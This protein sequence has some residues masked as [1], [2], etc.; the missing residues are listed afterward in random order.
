MNKKSEP[1]YIHAILYL[2]IV[3]LAYVLIRVA[4]IEPT[5]IVEAEKYYKSESRARMINIKAAEILWEKR[6]GSYTDNLDSL[7][8]FVK[9]DSLVQNL[10]TG[11]D[12]MTGR[13]SNPF[14]DLTA[15]NFIADSILLSPKSFTRYHLY[16][17]TT[18]TIDTV[19]NRRGK[20]TKIDSN[21][22]IGTKYFL[23][24]P[25]GYGTVGDS[26]DIALKN[27]ASWE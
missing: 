15:G 12:T 9:K 19:I 24:C 16:V 2:V 20:I 23:K 26:T 8:H 6:F 3:V 18:K 17:D 22:V 4:I 13:S 25:D 5:E 7:V 10:V 14:S 1:W 11:V 27:T 21:I